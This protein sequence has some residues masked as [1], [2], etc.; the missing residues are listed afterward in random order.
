M[1][2]L[3][4]HFTPVDAARPNAV[5]PHAQPTTDRPEAVAMLRDAF[6]DGV[7]GDETYAGE[8]T[9]FVAKGRIAEALQRLHA[10]GYSYL[11][12]LGGLD[13]FTEDDRY[14]VFYNVCDLHR[15]RRLRVKTRVDESDLHLPSATGVYRSANW[16]EREVFDMFGLVFDGH[17]D[18][19][20]MFMPEDFQ[21]YPL[22]KEFPLLGIPG[23]LPL[24][25]HL[26]GEDLSYDPFPAASSPTPKSFQEPEVS[27][28]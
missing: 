1:E 25:G 21:Y 22:R 6:G 13:R 7:T 27:G 28:E 9:V 4:F 11:A 3:K 8:T 18:L 15:G 24:P 5:N 12:D 20:R 14:E 2:S 17:E 16:F 23:S 26:P 19:R 10:D